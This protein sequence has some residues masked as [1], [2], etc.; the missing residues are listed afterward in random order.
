M[1]LDD[2]GMMVK[3]RRLSLKKIRSTMHHIHSPY[4]FAVQDFLRWATYRHVTYVCS[5]FTHENS[6]GFLVKWRSRFHVKYG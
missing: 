1:V 3:C 6:V 5:I 4:C 2:D